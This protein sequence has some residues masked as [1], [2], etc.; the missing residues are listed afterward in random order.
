MTM[1]RN[2]IRDRV[3]I[4][5]PIQRR[6]RPRL[7]SV[8]EDGRDNLQIDITEQ[9]VKQ[10]FDERRVALI[11]DVDSE[12]TLASE[13]LP[14]FDSLIEG[15]VGLTEYAEA[16]ERF[17][18]KINKAIVEASTVGDRELSNLLDSV[19]VDASGIGFLIESLGRS[20]NADAQF[21]SDLK[22]GTSV[23]AEDITALDQDV[24]PSLF[25]ETDNTRSRM[26]FRCLVD[27]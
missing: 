26:I 25:R 17:E 24:I 14:L 2:S 23:L 19:R 21:R 8:F 12:I 18:R 20:P 9:K 15:D 22:E 16:L 11:Q 3:M 6:R 27:L 1:V 13:E 4:E 5:V 7:P 10:C